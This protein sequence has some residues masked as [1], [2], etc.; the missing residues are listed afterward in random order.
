[1]KKLL[2]AIVAVGLYACADDLDQTNPN[3]L[4]T[5]NYWETPAQAQAGANAMY[6]SMLVDGAYMRIFP[7]LSDGRGDDTKADSPWADL[8]QVSNFTIPTTSAPVQ[9]IW[10]DSY[11]MIGRA[12]QVLANVPDIEMD[13]SLKDRI[14]GQAHFLRGLAYFNLANTFQV[15]P[16]V[17]MPPTNEEDFTPE[18]G[19]EDA[20]WELIM[21]DFRMAAS[22]LPVNYL[23]V[24]GPDAGDIGRATKGAATGYLAKANLYRKN[25]QAAADGFAQL[26]S[27]PLAVYSLVPNY[28]DNFL[29]VNENNAES[30]FEVQ[31]ASPSEVGG[32]D[33]NWAGEPL[34]TWKQVSAQAVTYGAD[35][36]GY[37]DFL[38][39]QWLYDA[40]KS[41]E[42]VD[43][44][45]DPRLL[46]TIASY[47]PEA[48]STTIYGNEWPYA[49][50]KIYPRK[51]TRDGFPGI[52]NEFDFNSGINYRLMRYADVLLMYAEALNELGRTEEAYGYIQQVRDRANLPDLAEVRPGMSQEEMRDQI[53]HER[54]LEFA[55]EGSRIN[56]IIR[57]GWLYDTEKLA[58]LQAHDPEFNS[59]SPGNE[60]LPVPQ[61]ELDVNPNLSPNPAN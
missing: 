52:A 1:M 49:E 18:T 15:V 55:L 48:N 4:T 5:A 17:T 9:W 2:Y 20:L 33:M 59:W 19:T 6:N 39:T 40:Y 37:S 50:D 57:W 34:A 27:G 31:F 28:R 46:T 42:T 11:M 36:F 35:E 3:Q 24:N 23:D 32:A 61:R 47:E 8:V 54:A 12:N 56:D 53:A 25:W 26:I 22:M 30:L 44:G 7:S 45:I 14:L 43:G 13:A 41:E 51:Y 60:Y 10:R 58:E 21:N 16:L 38:P 29:Q